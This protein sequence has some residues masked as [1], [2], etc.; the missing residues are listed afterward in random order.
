[1]KRYFELVKCWSTIPKTTYKLTFGILRSQAQQQVG[2]EEII[3][4]LISYHWTLNSYVWWLRRSLYCWTAC[5]PWQIPASL[6]Q[7]QVRLVIWVK[8][9]MRQF[10]WVTHTSMHHYWNG[11]T[12]W[13]L[14]PAL[15]MVGHKKP[16]SSHRELALMVVLSQACGPALAQKYRRRGHTPTIWK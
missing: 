9:W 13:L 14:W 16:L 5:A 12:Y 2:L 10:S 6:Q 11:C 1:M 7:G 8:V 4:A 15:E 3:L